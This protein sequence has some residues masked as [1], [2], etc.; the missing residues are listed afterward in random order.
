MRHVK[1]YMESLGLQSII[2]LKTDENCIIR[3]ED[4]LTNISKFKKLRK[5]L[6]LY[7]LNFSWRNLETKSAFFI[8]QIEIVIGKE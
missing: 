4:N 1:K 8:P 2:I 6:E 3:I 7:D 5:F